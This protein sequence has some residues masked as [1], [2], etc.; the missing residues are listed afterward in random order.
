MGFWAL[1]YKWPF[2]LCVTWANKRT[3]NTHCTLRMVTLRVPV[4]TLCQCQ[5]SKC[6]LNYHRTLVFVLNAF[7]SILIC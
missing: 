2:V 7:G 6:L 5:I 1:V 4:L 3:A